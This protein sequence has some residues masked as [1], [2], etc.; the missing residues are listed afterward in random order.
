MPKVR[1]EDVAEGGFINDASGKATERVRK[2]FKGKFVGDDD[3]VPPKS[4]G[5][6]SMKKFKP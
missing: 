6:P 1:L 5:N 2:N 4:K 3:P